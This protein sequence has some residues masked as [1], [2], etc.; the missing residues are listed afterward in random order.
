MQL[1]SE[2]PLKKPFKCCLPFTGEGLLRKSRDYCDVFVQRDQGPWTLSHK[3]LVIN[4][5]QVK[6]FFL[7]V[8]KS[9]TNHKL[10]GYTY[11]S[12]Q[13]TKYKTQT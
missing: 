9:I 12:K 3:R 6:H 5:D 13:N 10:L 7:E 2:Q 1:E 8:W 11:Y 4:L